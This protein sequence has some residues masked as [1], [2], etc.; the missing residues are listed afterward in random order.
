MTD[1]TILGIDPGTK[2]M[3]IAVLQGRTL[4]AHG[5]HTLRNGD[6]P[7]DVIGQAKAIVLRYIADYGPQIVAI[8]KPYAIATKRAALLSVIEQELSARAAEL[9][10]RVVQLSPEEIRQAVVG[11]PRARKLDVARALVDRG[12]GQLRVRLPKPPARAALGL[13]A[14][15]RYWLHM[16]DALAVAAAVQRAKGCGPSSH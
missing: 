12:F 9:R 7:H 1:P 4:R 8:E 10:L 3:G 11:N 15:D 14:K 13:S 16:F 2:E 5:V 6:H